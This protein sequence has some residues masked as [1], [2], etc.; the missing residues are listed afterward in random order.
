MKKLIGAILAA[1]I[2]TAVVPGPLA[3]AEQGQAS[4][5][6]Q[7]LATG[8]SGVQKQKHK[9]PKKGKHHKKGKHQ[10]KN[11]KADKAPQLD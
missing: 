3:L 5:S 4:T 9:T 11:G 10:K 6:G 2:L 8:T 1:F 7:T